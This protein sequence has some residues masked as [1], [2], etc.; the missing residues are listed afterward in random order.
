MRLRANMT[1]IRIPI[2]PVHACIAQLGDATHPAFVQLLNAVG[3]GRNL[4][5]YELYVTSAGASS[6]ARSRARRTSAPLTLA[7]TTTVGFTS[8]RDET[9]LT[10]ITA[11]LNGCTAIGTNPPFAES[12]SFWFDQTQALGQGRVEILRP[13]DYPMLVKP[14]SAIELAYSANSAAIGLN[15]FAVWDEI[16]A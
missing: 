12:A 16:T 11:V 7:G 3:S 15:V 10:S 9:D 6:A 4:R 14:G 2:S 1:D 5:V 8:R 13:G